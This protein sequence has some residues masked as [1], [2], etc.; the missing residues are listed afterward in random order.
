M[1]EQVYPWLKSNYDILRGMFTDLN[2]LSLDI[3]SLKGA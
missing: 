3:L 1:V 2:S